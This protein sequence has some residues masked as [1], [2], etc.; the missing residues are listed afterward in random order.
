MGEDGLGAGGG[1]RRSHRLGKDVTRL[2]GPFGRPRL[3][4]ARTSSALEAL[5][6]DALSPFA[7]RVLEILELGGCA[8]YVVGGAV[9]DLLIGR[10]LHDVDIATALPPPAVERC[11]DAQGIVVIDVGIRFGT[12]QAFSPDTGETVEVT[13]LRREGRYEDARHPEEVFWTEDLT[14]DLARRDFTVNALAWR[15]L[16][17]VTDARPLEGG[18][19]TPGGGRLYDPFDGLPDLARRTLRAVGTATDRLRE[20]PLRVARLFRFAAELGFRPEPA[21]RQAA[22]LAATDLDRVSRERVRDEL[23]RLLMADALWDVGEDVA[24]VLLPA[25]IPLWREL[26]AFEESR[27]QGALVGPARKQI[28]HKPVDLHSVLT[29]SLVPKRPVL[30]WAALLHDL[31]KPRTFTLGSNGRVQFHGH[32]AASGEMA[33]LALGQLRFPPAFIRAVC[34]LIEVHLFPWEEASETG[35]RRLIRRLG[36]DGARDLLELHRADVEASTPLG[37][38]QYEVVREALEEIL[39]AR[40]PVSERALAIDG[41]DV[42]RVLDL[43]PSPEVGKVL[44]GLLEWVLAHPGMNERDTLLGMVRSGA[45]RETPPDDPSQVAARPAR[46]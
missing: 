16:P 23:S 14:E 44:R 28:V 6:V 11:L 42:M 24:R 30:R 22:R 27:W 31:G 19:E 43:G 36:E 13:T 37:W 7:V 12:V 34:A 17:R 35:Y 29:A 38:M 40:P 1:R 2:R 18:M 32:E 10:A 45:W 4:L 15:P 9:R 5:Q 41:R 33:R 3:P 39:A 25:A 46:P 21:T 20:D 8:A 26:T